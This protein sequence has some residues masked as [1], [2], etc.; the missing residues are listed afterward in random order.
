MTVPVPNSRLGKSEHKGASLRL[1]CLGCVPFGVFG[2]LLPA[3]MSLTSIIRLHRGDRVA[4][5]NQ[6]TLTSA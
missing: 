3:G 5:K 1:C 2:L 4:I 6:C